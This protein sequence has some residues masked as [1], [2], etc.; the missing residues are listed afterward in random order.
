MFAQ[1]VSTRCSPGTSNL[2][3]HGTITHTKLKWTN[4]IMTLC[5]L[6]ETIPKFYQWY[7]QQDEKMSKKCAY[8]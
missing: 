2:K 4:S 7:S 3:T 5:P 1:E 6:K 8:R